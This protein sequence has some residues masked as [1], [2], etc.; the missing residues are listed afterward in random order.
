MRAVAAQNPHAFQVVGPGFRDT[1]RVSSG[2][3]GM[4]VGILRENAV[5]V[6]SALDALVTQLAEMRRILS[7][8]S[9]G[10]ETLRNFLAVA[11]Q[12]RDQI[13]FPT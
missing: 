5:A 10:D 7:D 6:V 4:W 2:P 11:K 13:Q 3:P 12:T 9:T 1:T 8:P